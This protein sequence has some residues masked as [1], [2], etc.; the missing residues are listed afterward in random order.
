MAQ[1]TRSNGPRIR[2]LRE[3]AGMTIDEFVAALAAE[4]VERH[5]DTIRRGETGKANLG[6]PVVN[7]AARVLNVDRSEI[8]LDEAVPVP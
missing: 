4:G 3:A 7:A 6:W 5:P 1:V 2:A 8:T